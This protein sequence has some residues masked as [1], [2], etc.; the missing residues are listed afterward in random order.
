VMKQTQKRA[1]AP[2]HFCHRTIALLISS[3]SDAI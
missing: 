1:I 3:Y 2:R